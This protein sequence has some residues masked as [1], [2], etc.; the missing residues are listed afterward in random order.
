MEIEYLNEKVEK[1]CTS[2]KAAC[3]LF[4]G[5]KTLAKFLASRITSL[6]AAKVIRDIIVQP[7]LR[8]HNLH[9]KGGSRL[10]GYYAIDVK[11]IKER[12]RIILQ[13]LDD[14]HEA[15]N[16]C[17][18]DEISGTVRNVLIKEVSNHYE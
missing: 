17:N 1:Q 12:W 3:K 16:P 10:E 14:N 5:D 9:N 2:I 4:G 8:F 15:F 18:I 7:Q 11:S 6:K 13:P